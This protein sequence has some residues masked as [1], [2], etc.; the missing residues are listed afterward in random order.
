MTKETL[1]A[2]LPDYRHKLVMIKKRQSVS[3]ILKEVLVSHEFFEKDYD[4]I[5]AK[6]LGGS[7]LE[8]AKRIFNFL[9][10]NVRYYE[11]PESKQVIKSPAAIIETGV[12]DCKCYASFIGGVLDAINRQGG[13]FVWNY[14][15]ASYT[16]GVD[17]PGHVFV[18]ID[19][20]G[21]EYWIDPVLSSFDKRRPVPKVIHK[22]FKV[23]DMALY[24]LS[25]VD[26]QMQVVK[27][28][29][30]SCYPG[31]ISGVSEWVKENPLVVAAGAALV[32]YFLLKK[33]R[34]R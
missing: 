15:F 6:F 28:N 24:R 20:D 8:I 3:D 27:S 33:N 12:C 25:G 13:E 11:E 26:E 1:L 23:D 7:D 18:Q 5:A 4:T 31:K 10:L 30:I 19:I 16:A 14:A 21:T 9:K 32:M 29:K 22:K 2:V 17:T 34:R